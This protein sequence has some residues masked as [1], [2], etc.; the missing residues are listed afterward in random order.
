MLLRFHAQHL[1]A[2]LRELV[3][4]PETAT[5]LAAAPEAGRLLRP[6]WRMLTRDR[7]PEVLRLPR[8]PR[9]SGAQARSEAKP[10]GAG[11][12]RFG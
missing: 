1:V 12:P 2:G 11:A 6:L 5:L 8:R 10:D 4:A 9:R 7:L 3:E